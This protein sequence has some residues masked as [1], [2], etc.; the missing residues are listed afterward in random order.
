[1]VR[2]GA[3]DDPDRDTAAATDH[4]VNVLRVDPEDEMDLSHL[5]ISFLLE[6]GDAE[7]DKAAR[8][9]LATHPCEC[10]HHCFSQTLSDYRKL[11]GEDYRTRY[12][13]A[14]AIA[15]G[16][17]VPSFLYGQWE[18]PDGIPAN[19][20]EEE[21]S[22]SM[23]GRE[24]VSEQECAL[25][26]SASAAVELMPAWRAS[27]SAQTWLKDTCEA[28]SAHVGE[29]RDDPSF[30][31]GLEGA[32]VEGLARLLGVPE[33]MPESGIEVT[34]P[35]AVW[36]CAG[37]EQPPTGYSWTQARAGF[38]FWREREEEDVAL[39]RLKDSLQELIEDR[40]AKAGLEP[41]TGTAPY[42]NELSPVAGL[43]GQPAEGVSPLAYLAAYGS[44]AQ[45]GELAEEL[46]GLRISDFT[47]ITD[48]ARAAAY[49]RDLGADVFEGEMNDQE[50]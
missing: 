4:L 30:T 37:S 17:L 47:L 22:L 34:E 5:A 1:M 13:L 2:G 38:L 23:G 8:H 24:D 18:I 50:E 45:I 40:L 15:S 20:T 14:E 19:L 27:P 26:L 28:L 43:M 7:S 10:V 35:P 3:S 42:P 33:G 9:I 44:A 21:V 12:S 49:L 48:D 25:I 29:R 39:A 36:G 41:Q 31:G 46:L 16:P 32:G 11:G 6:R